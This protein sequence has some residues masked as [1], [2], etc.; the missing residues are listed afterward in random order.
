MSK[1]CDYVDE[2]CLVVYSGDKV[3]KSGETEDHGPPKSIGNA[4][5]AQFPV[6][7]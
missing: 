2:W 4:K 6:I 5:P 3:V 7:A 1:W